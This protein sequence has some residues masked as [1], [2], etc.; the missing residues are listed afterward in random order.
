MASSFRQSL[1]RWLP[2]LA[3]A[4]LIVLF[5]RL[6][7]WQI[8][9]AAE[10]DEIETNYRQMT[11]APLKRLGRYRQQQDFQ[12]IIINGQWLAGRTLLLDNQVRDKQPG[13]HVFN[14]LRPDGGGPLLL[15]NRGW[16][17]MPNRAQPP[18]PEQL[19]KPVTLAG[20]LTR[21]PATGIVLG[22]QTL[23]SASQ[24]LVTRIETDQIASW[25]GESVAGQVLLAT[26]PTAFTSD[27][28][29]KFMPA[30]RHRGYAFQWFALAATV[31]LVTLVLQWRVQRKTDETTD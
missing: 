5:T 29:P 27:W 22:E 21:P 18:R 1:L 24:Q 25:L 11:S 17:A 7:F 6:G 26:G 16:L 12:P 15:V 20:K 3:A 31:L 10:K 14:L 13:V 19:S 4:C 2:V 28:A 9:R 23:T 30:S 8:E